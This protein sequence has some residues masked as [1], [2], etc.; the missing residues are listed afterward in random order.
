ML[1]T[2]ISRRAALLGAALAIVEDIDVD[3]ELLYA[4]ALLHDVALEGGAGVV[5]GRARRA[6]GRS[7]G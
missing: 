1:D 7:R 3:L 4:A 2:R 6:G 5:V